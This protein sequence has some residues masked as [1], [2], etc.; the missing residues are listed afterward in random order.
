[1]EPTSKKTAEIYKVAF[2]KLY[3]VKDDCVKDLDGGPASRGGLPLEDS[4]TARSLS[5]ACV[6][7]NKRARVMC[8]MGTSSAC[9]FLS[10]C[11]K[12]SLSVRG[13]TQGKIQ[14]IE[15]FVSAKVSQE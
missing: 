1:M 5:C 10:V 3:C 9:F 11:E 14:R 2:S 12:I 15:E 8:S 4:P 7:S 13:L 6:R